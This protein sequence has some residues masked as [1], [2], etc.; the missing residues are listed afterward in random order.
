MRVAGLTK[1]IWAG[2]SL[3][4]VDE[5]SSRWDV[6][7]FV[8]TKGNSDILEAPRHLSAG[9]FPPATHSAFVD[10]RA[11]PQ[12]AIAAFSLAGEEGETMQGL[13]QTMKT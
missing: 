6:Q 8:V 11:G 13:R 7:D 2:F 10:H 4:N 3:C 12:H 9:G 1:V 5:C